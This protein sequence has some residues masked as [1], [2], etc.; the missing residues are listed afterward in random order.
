MTTPSNVTPQVRFGLA[1]FDVYVVALRFYR[2]AVV[3]C[4][5]LR[6]KAVDHLLGA[7]ESA[8]LNIAEGHPAIGAERARKFRIADGEASECAGALD[9]LEVQGALAPVTLAQL[10][11]LL[12]RELAMLFRL[13]RRRR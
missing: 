3:A 7:A 13:G 2:E 9:L 4:R 1:S 5:D 10:R 11:A 12:D 8:V 6:G